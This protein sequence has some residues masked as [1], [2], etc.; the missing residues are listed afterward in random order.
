MAAID[1][2]DSRV[3]FTAFLPSLIHCSAVP[4]GGRGF[5]GHCPA[6]DNPAHRGIVAKTVGVVDILV[7]GEAAKHRL[8]EL[9]DQ[10]AAAVRSGPAVGQHT[11]GHLGQTERVIQLAERQQPGVRGNLRTVEFE[12]QAAAEIERNSTTIFFTRRV[13]HERPPA[14]S[15]T[16]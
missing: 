6:A 10:A 16:F 12:L 8:P 2:E 1:R 15:S 9:R 11:P 3:H 14:P 13:C 4:P 7:S 5:L